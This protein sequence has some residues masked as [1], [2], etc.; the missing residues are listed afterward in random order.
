MG[1]ILQAEPPAKLLSPSLSFP[2]AARHLDAHGAAH[3]PQPAPDSPRSCRSSPLMPHAPT[4]P[5]N[6]PSPHTRA[7]H[8]LPLERPPDPP[9]PSVSFPR[10]TTS[11]TSSMPK[12]FPLPPSMPLDYS[13]YQTPS[14]PPPPQQNWLGCRCLPCLRRGPPPHTCPSSSLRLAHPSPTPP[15]HCP[16][17]MMPDCRQLL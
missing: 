11:P 8:R 10:P 15:S 4:G 1:P 14:L 2:V 9:S 16:T 17:G 5:P 13:E 6:F 3:R 12:G 7:A